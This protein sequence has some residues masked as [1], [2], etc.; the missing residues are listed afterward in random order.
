MSEQYL[1]AGMIVN[2]H[3]IRGEVKINPWAD[4]PGF[5]LSFDRLFV[6]GKP[7]Q[8][9]SS[10]VHKNCV[11]VAFEGIT[12]I[13]DAVRLKN[14]TVYIDRSDV[15]LPE[16]EYFVSDLIGLDAVDESGAKLGTI[17]EIISL[18]PHNVYVIQG[19]REI[20][21]PAVPEFVKQVDIEGGRVVF[22]LIEGM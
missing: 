16:G 14:K 15:S 4:S 10:R 17:S 18:E 22:K 20:L 8:V 6:D 9:V 2:T 5:L 12:G 13:D 21:V 7:L 3:G 1:E 19:S 11:I